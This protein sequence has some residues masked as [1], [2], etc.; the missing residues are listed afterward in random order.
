MQG[1]LVQPALIGGLTMGVLSALPL[2]SAGNV[3]CCLWVVTGGIV[4]AYLLQQNQPAPVRLVDGA[5]V[6]LLAGVVGAFVYVLLS[7][8]M[9]ILTAPAQRQL[10]ERFIDAGTLP[11]EFRD[12]MTRYAFGALGLTVAFVATL[13][14]GLVFSPIGGLIG[15]AIF[16]RPMPHRDPDGVPAPP[17]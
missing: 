3:C 13:I 16:R 1:S 7:I 14:A 4:A 11:A 15:A 6:G 2:V 8:P 9:M 17:E 12:Y 10:V 5:V